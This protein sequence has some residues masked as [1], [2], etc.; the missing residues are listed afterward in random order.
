MLRTGGSTP[1]SSRL[2]NA[3]MAVEVALAIVVL[4]AAGLFFR[5]FMETRDSDPG[6]R[7]DGVLLAAYDLSGRRVDAAAARSFASRVLDRL[8]AVPALD[9]VAIASSVPLDIHGMP[10]RVFTLEGRAREDGMPDEALAN[11]VTPGYFNVMAIPLVAGTDFVSLDDTAAPP[12]AV[13]NE[14]FVRRYLD[15]AQPLGRRVELGGR[16]YSIIGVVRNALYNAFGDP[17]T[18]IIYVSYRDR[19]SPA[20][21]IHLRTRPGAETAVAPEVRRIVR[22]LDPDLPIFDVRTLNDHIE[23]NLILRRIPARMFAVLAPLLLLM[24]AIGIYA[25]VSYT[26]SL[27]TTEIGVRLALGATG[28]RIVAQFV[29]ES[30]RV[31]GAGAIAGWVI[32]FVL[33]VDVLSGGPIDITVFAVVPAIL[34]AVATIAACLPAR[35]ATRVDPAIALREA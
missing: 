35:R 2:R 28:R 13:V 12:Q 1:P 4:V 17:P 29:G 11:T 10:T 34:L 33:A 7:R 22:D 18:P 21:E 26:V 20:G 31:I 23:S 9:G 14:E 25:V 5:S 15:R 8:R 27:R 32:A 3:L 16:A 6:F 30:L 24:A 19:P